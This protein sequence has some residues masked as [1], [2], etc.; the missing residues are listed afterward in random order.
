MIDTL[1]PCPMCGDEGDP[2]IAETKLKD[3]DEYNGLY[4]RCGNCGLNIL[5]HEYCYN[6]SKEIAKEK[7]TKE[8]NKRA[9][10]KK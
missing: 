7:A 1:K 4:V 6:E 10:V 8:W 5:P 3:G 2:Q 9:E